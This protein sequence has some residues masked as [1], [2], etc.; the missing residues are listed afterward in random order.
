MKEQFD[1][2]NT[3]WDK[4]APKDNKYNLWSF[5]MVIGLLIFILL[6]L[7]LFTVPGWF[8]I[9]LVTLIFKFLH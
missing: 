5:L 7:L 4:L 2:I 1:I 9:V 8:V 6:N 3:S